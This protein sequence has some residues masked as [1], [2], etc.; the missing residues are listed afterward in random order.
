M[1]YRNKP[2]KVCGEENSSK[3]KVCLECKTQFPPRKS[4][5]GESPFDRKNEYDR[6][7]K[8]D[9]KSKK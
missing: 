4:T 5:K 8:A 1:K 9:R 3:R 6:K 7:Q 2:C